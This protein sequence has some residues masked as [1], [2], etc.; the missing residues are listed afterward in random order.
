MLDSVDAGRAALT[1][2]NAFTDHL[3]L[4]RTESIEWEGPTDFAEMAFL[5][6]QSATSLAASIRWCW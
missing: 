2:V 6:T 4:G 3:D 1:D 5:S